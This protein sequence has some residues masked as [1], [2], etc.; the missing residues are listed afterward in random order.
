[1]PRSKNS[2]SKDSSAHLG[3]EAKLWL[4]V[5]SFLGTTA[6][7]CCTSHSP[8]LLFAFAVAAAVA[9]EFTPRHLPGDSGKGYRLLLLPIFAAAFAVVVLAFRAMPEWDGTPARS[10]VARGAVRRPAKTRPPLAAPDRGMAEGRHP[11]EIHDPASHDPQVTVQEQT[12]PDQAAPD[13]ATHP[14][15]HFEGYHPDPLAVA[16]E[17]LKLGPSADQALPAPHNLAFLPGNVHGDAANTEVPGA[18]T[19]AGVLD[20]APIAGA[21]DI[22]SVVEWKKYFMPDVKEPLKFNRYLFTRILSHGTVVSGQVINGSNPYAADDSNRVSFY[23]PK[24]PNN[25]L[26]VMEGSA[27]VDEKAG[28]LVGSYSLVDGKPSLRL[29]FAV[30]FDGDTLVPATKNSTGVKIVSIK[31]N[32]LVLEAN[33]KRVVV[34]GVAGGEGAPEDKMEN[35]PWF[36]PVWAGS[37]GDEYTWPGTGVSRDWSP[38]KFT[39]VRGWDDD[40]GRVEGWHTESVGSVRSVIPAGLKR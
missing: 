34:V 4:A 18:A 28:A 14:N 24:L 40:G 39:P 10:A 15:L 27:P 20:A 16:P 37:G 5:T 36:A 12:V 3:F 38:G 22:A 26:T 17:Q 2:G 9:H 29:G 31:E 13:K 32:R 1:M 23:F 11:A 8:Q 7:W 30:Y 25:K 35:L 6:L 33:E 21:L 19:V